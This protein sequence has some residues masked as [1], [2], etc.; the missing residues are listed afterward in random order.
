MLYCSA[1]TWMTACAQQMMRPQFYKEFITALQSKYHLSDHG[2]LDWHL[3]MKF[4]RD[5]NNGSISIDQK[6]YIESLVNRFDMKGC[7]PKPTQMV[8]GLHLS[9][10]DC[11]ATPDKEQTRAYQQ[12]IGSLMYVA[13]G[14]RPDIA[15]TVSTCA[16]FMSNPW[17]RH[18]EAAKHIIRYLKGTS[19]VG[20][21]QIQ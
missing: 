6:A 15:Y 19:H 5:K 4:T 7:K 8:P 21:S 13:C 10:E 14:T 12:L 11:P 20:L 16:Q 1:S 3:C 9:K 2:N 17:P 18:M